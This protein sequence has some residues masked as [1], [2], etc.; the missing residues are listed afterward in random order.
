LT[1]IDNTSSEYLFIVEFFAKDDKPNAELARDIFSEIFNTTIKMG[2]VC[3]HSN[4]NDLMILFI[5]FN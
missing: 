5:S 2:L 4:I 3:I 1:F